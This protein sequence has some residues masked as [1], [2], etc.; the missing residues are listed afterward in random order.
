MPKR[1]IFQF[2]EQALATAN[3]VIDPRASRGYI[4]NEIGGYGAGAGQG[5]IITVNDERIL[6]VPA[7][8]GLTG[9]AEPRNRNAQTA[10]LLEQLYKQFPDLPRIHAGKDEGIT[11]ERATTVGACEAILEYEEWEGDD[12]MPPD[13]PGGS[14]NDERLFITV[15][16][17]TVAVAAGVTIVHDVVNGTMPTGFRAFPWTEVC[18]SNRYMDLLGIAV[19]YDNTASPTTTVDG[20]RVWRKEQSILANNEDFCEVLPFPVTDATND[21]RLGLFKEPIRF[22]PND[23]LRVQVQYTN[24]GGA[25][26]TPIIGCVLMFHQI[27]V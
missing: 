16:T 22:E 1:R 17:H 7:I 27:P 12:V 6:F 19:G 24:G 26:E 5:L 13:V 2:E 3:L 23:E 14:L 11:I 21:R 4:I 15:A 9:I 10:G 25:P 18:P 20:I 8:A